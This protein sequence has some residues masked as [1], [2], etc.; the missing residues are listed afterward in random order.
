M[1]CRIEINVVNSHRVSNA[2]T[3]LELND[4]NAVVFYEP[5][6]Y[7]KRDEDGDMSQRHEIMNKRKE[8]A[9]DSLKA[10]VSDF[11]RWLKTE[12]ITLK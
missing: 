10:Q 8:M 7:T 4:V 11:V 9:V 3:V 1:A 5:I 12:K 2:I 6:P